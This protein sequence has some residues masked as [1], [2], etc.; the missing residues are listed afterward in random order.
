MRYIILFSAPLA[1]H[2]S[3]LDSE[4]NK[5]VP[6]DINTTNKQIAAATTG[7]NIVLDISYVR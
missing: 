3:S 4:L 2:L 5:N 7:N 6:E 1:V